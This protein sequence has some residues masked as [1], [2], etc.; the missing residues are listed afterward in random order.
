MNSRRAEKKSSPY[1]SDTEKK[2]SQNRRKAVRT[3]GGL[4]PPQLTE[5]QEKIIVI[6]GTASVEGVSGGLDT[7]GDITSDNTC[8]GSTP[9]PIKL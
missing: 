4:V 2:T 5:L 6:I 8:S 7:C 1:S 9:S 3:G